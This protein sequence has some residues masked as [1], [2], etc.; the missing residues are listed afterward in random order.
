MT[1][2]RKRAPFVRGVALALFVLYLPACTTW[3]RQSFPVQAVILDEHP[4]RIRLTRLNGSRVEI[5]NPRIV[6]DSI[7][8]ASPG[9]MRFFAA[10]ALDD[11]RI[12][13]TQ[14]I[15]AGK[16]TLVMVG[17]GIAALAVVAAA[18]QDD[19]P[20]PPPPEYISCPLVY[21]WDG[22]AWRLDSGTFG[23]AITRAATRTDVDNLI[24]AAAHAGRLRL[25]LANELDET[26]H[27]DAL[28]V[29]V[30]DHDPDVT[31]APDGDGNL[32]NLG[33]LQTP[34]GASDFRGRDVLQLVAAADELNW[35]SAPFGR[36]P[37]RAED[38]R[39]GLV[40]KFVRPAGVNSGKL[41]ID[42][43]NTTWASYMLTELIEAHGT[44]TDAWYDSL[45][46]Q[47]RFRQ[48]F[49]SLAAHTGF[50]GV[51][52]HTAA[53][54]EHQGYVWEAGPEIA[55]RQVFP[56]DLSRVRG[57]TVR[58]RLESAPSFWLI[59]QVALDYS[60]SQPFTVQEVSATRAIDHA[61]RDVRHLLAAVDQRELV[62]ETGDYVELH[63]DLPPAEPGKTRSFVLRSTGWYRVHT[64][65][66]AAPQ[67]TLLR[68][69]VSDRD[70]PSRISVRRM[71]EAWRVFGVR[72][73]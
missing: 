47:P 67:I 24:Y 68:E 10:V 25:K 34:L 22:E 59:D 73:Q 36:S 31:V 39:D 7:V 62:M 35:Q 44:A 28:S 3:R 57:D 38:I 43:R 13:E 69:T 20:P 14:Q 58:V 64:S 32:H 51:S 5:T 55:K 12:V 63:F 49:A 66:T 11:I 1:V 21:S 18:A 46:T 48:Q 2:L 26:D 70:A 53:G 42:G 50:L 61:G 30:V 27:V 56:L 33:K 65:P 37:D 29:L 71:N 8:G 4:K 45:D 41:V 6:G 23:G 40:L 15:H 60:M 54:W 9:S 52:I 72:T 17:L 16:T 19:P